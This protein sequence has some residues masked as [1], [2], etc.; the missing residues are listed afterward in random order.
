[1]LEEDSSLV[2]LLNEAMD[3]GERD[4]DAAVRNLR[5]QV[6]PRARRNAE[7]AGATIVQHPRARELRIRLCQRTAERA[8]TSAAL[9]DALQQHDADALSRTMRR[10]RQLALDMDRLEQDIQRARQEPAQGGC[11]AGSVGR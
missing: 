1:M 9:A 8:E 6:V 3:V 10:M 4:T 11:S 5:E 7:A 2:T